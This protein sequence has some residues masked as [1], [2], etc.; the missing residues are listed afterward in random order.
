MVWRNDLLIGLVAGTALAVLALGSADAATADSC[1]GISRRL[2]ICTSASTDGRGVD[3]T[4]TVRRDEPGARGAAGAPGQ[5]GRPLTADE[6]QDLLDQ[7]CYGNGECGTRIAGTVNPLIPPQDPAAP[8]P[9]GAPATV[10]I[11][12]V[13]R[14]LPATTGLHVEPDGWAVV[15]VPANLWV[16]VTPMTVDGELLDRPAEVRFTPIAYRFD[17]GDGTVRTSATGGAS[18]AALGQEELTATPT[19]HVYTVR[20]DRRAT[21]T[22]VYAAAYRFADGPWTDV[23][24]A[25]SGTTAPQRVLV[26]VER[27]ALTAAAAAG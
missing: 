19:S 9:A 21:V 22:I 27:T 18:W 5:P 24:G 6:V 8:A 3:V 15:G 12:D 2:G 26:V 11:A 13:A 14:F 25:V 16:E 20:A 17:Y 23:A 4:G 10:G 7:V 1:T